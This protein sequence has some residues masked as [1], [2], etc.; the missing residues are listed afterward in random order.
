M[1]TVVAGGFQLVT[2]IRRMEINRRI[3]ATTAWTEA[4]RLRPAG[5]LLE[6]VAQA[7]GWL[8]AA[9]T[10]FVR[11]G[12]PLSVGEVRI[13]ADPIPGAPVD[14]QAE[15]LAWRDSSAVLRG[16]ASSGGRVLGKADSGICGLLPADHL[17][18]PAATHAL[19]V[20]LLAAPA[21]ASGARAGAEPPGAPRIETLDA[22]RAR[23]TWDVAGGNDLF[24]EH[25]PRMPILPGSYQV[26]ALVEMAG[27][28]A[29]AR[30]GSPGRLAA[31]RRV[32]FRRPVRPGDRV[33]LEAEMLE[34][35]PGRAVLTARAR[36]TGE[37]AASI[38]EIH[39]GPTAWTEHGPQT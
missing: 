12:L 26:Q 30:N 23:A 35:A 31:I 36:V 19:Y 5:F 1:E 13:L 32:R 14:L 8:I 24:A 6:A 10:G 7:A 17:D 3:E 18:D 2:S 21:A 33:T 28:V 37:Q 29:G 27:A 4:D 9:S 39:V 15:I 20:A 34:R 38:G 25:F 16:Q 22:Q 11:R